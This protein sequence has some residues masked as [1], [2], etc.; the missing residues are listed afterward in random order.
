MVPLT[1]GDYTIA[2]ICALPLEVA[3]AQVMLDEIHQKLPKPTAD[4]NAYILGKLHGHHI[5]I[6]C[7]PTGIYGTISAATIVSHLVSTFPKVEY[8]LMVGIGGGVPSSSN[9]IRLGDIV[10]SKPVGKYSGVIQYDHGK[11]VQGGRFEQTGT[12]NSP[13]LI[14]LTHMA[15]LQAN[16]ITTNRDLISNIVS[17]VLEQNP[18]MKKEFASPSHHTDYLFRSSYQHIDQESDCE[19][20]DKQELLDR[21]PRDDTTPHVHYGLIASGDQVMKDPETRDALAQRL[22]ILCFEME[23]AGLMNQLPTLVIRG[24]CDYCDSHKNKLWQGYAALTAAAYA[25]LLLSVI[26]ETQSIRSQALQQGLS[27]VPFDWSPRIE[28]QN[29]E[30]AN[31]EQLRLVPQGLRGIRQTSITL[32]SNPET[33]SKIRKAMD[34]GTK[35]IRKETNHSPRRLS[36]FRNCDESC[37]CDCH[38][39]HQIKCGPSARAIIGT[40]ILQYKGNL[41]FRRSCNYGTCKNN[42]PRT[43]QAIYRFPTWLKDF[44]LILSGVPSCGLFVPRQL[45]WGSTETILKSAYEGNVEG[46][47]VLLS[48][49]A[50]ALHDIDQ[51][52]GRSALHVS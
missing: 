7:L 6:A 25:K 1:H 40:F 9:D 42:N 17:D 11:T 4:P 37:L 47:K 36:E 44:T 32:Q 10:V 22:G 38:K 16:Q 27:M 18:G 46:L 21:E 35:S 51:K 3:A 39:K 8:A 12:L 50:F 13:P 43:I 48:N 52:H 29:R 2:W 20:C 23:A 24:I 5:V 45:S 26:P 28:E 49:M 41:F 19:K 31:L 33:C 34:G 15:Y 30:S 14:L